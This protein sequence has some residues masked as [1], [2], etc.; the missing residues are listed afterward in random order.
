MSTANRGGPRA[1]RRTNTTHVQRRPMMAIRRT[2]VDMVT[3][4]TR[5]TLLAPTGSRQ[6]R[7]ARIWVVVETAEASEKPLELYFGT[8]ANAAV[9]RS[10]IID[11]LTI[12]NAG[13]HSARTY[14]ANSLDR[15]PTGLKAEVI[16]YRW[17]AAPASAHRA[18]IE[19]RQH[20]TNRI[21]SLT[22]RD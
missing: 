16:S 19:Y 2:W 11:T 3:T 21:C 12:K 6:L 13:S 22:D 1:G 8:G 4:T 9:D 17:T 18:F 5:T 7:I 14:D 15:S 20:D 10:K